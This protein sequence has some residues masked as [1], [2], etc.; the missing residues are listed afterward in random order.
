M[1]GDAA[2]TDLFGGQGTLA[3]IGDGTGFH[4]LPTFWVDANAPSGKYSATLRLHDLR[5][6]GAALPSGD[7]T[8][9]FA[10]PAAVPEPG[11][12]L[13]LGSGLLALTVIARRR[14]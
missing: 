2:D 12:L 4:F 5:A 8:F 14:S 3:P 11:T 10:V 13:L 7:F 9:D 1:L 6:S